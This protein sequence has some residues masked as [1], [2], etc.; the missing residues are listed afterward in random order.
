MDIRRNG[1]YKLDEHILGL[2][3]YEKFLK[4]N[5]PEDTGLLYQVNGVIETIREIRKIIMD[6]KIKF[7]IKNY[8]MIRDTFDRETSVYISIKIESI[9]F[10][11]IPRDIWI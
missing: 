2:E 3:N 7:F 5:H 9:A 10:D 6:I 11:D 8:E 1:I 4:D